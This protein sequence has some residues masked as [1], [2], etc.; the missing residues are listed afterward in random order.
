MVLLCLIFPII[1]LLLQI[2]ADKTQ[3]H[4]RF[5][6]EYARSRQFD[7]LDSSMWYSSLK[8][9]ILREVCRL[10]ELVVLL[11]THGYRRKEGKY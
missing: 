4:R 8:K 3:H 2:G 5:F 9:E 1:I 7:P 10:S 6:D 11:I